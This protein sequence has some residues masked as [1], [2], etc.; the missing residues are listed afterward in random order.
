MLKPP[1]IT[2]LEIVR[3]KTF[4]QIIRCETPKLIYKPIT[5]ITK[6]GPPVITATAHGVPDGWRVAIV[7]VQGMTEINARNWP[8]K[9]EDF[10]RAT[11]LTVNTIELNSVNASNFKAY[12]SGGYVVYKEPYSLVSHTA[13]MQ[14]R[15]PDTSALLADL[16]I[17][18]GGIVID[19][20][21]CTI[22]RMIK[23]SD[24]AGFSWSKGTFDCELV[25]P[26]ATP[27]VY[28]LDSGP[29]KVSDE[30]TQ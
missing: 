24:T 18:N 12:T 21:A 6:N 3:G 5:G 14:I 8:L 19:D 29:V 7:G 25:T 13:R 11:A 30:V 15:D 16:T 2:D 10:I 17:A 28:L 20:V 27:I 22:T 23:A 1:R 26:D 4:K 9:D